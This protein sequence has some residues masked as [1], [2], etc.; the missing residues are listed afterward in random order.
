MRRLLTRIGK[1]P[2]KAVPWIIMTFG[3]CASLWLAWDDKSKLFTI[4]LGLT[5]A[6][7]AYQ[8]ARAPLDAVRAR[9]EM[10]ATN[11][12]AEMCEEPVKSVFDLFDKMFVSKAK[13]PQAEV[14]KRM[15]DIRKQMIVRG[16]ADL[17]LEWERFVEAVQRNSELEEKIAASER[18]FRALR[19]SIGHDDTDVPFGTF[20]ATY[21]TSE[22]RRKIS[23]LQ[24]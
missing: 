12:R 11:K 20:M 21:L 9:N 10:E 3:A 2:S 5:T 23:K 15:M 1:A 16:E 6:A 22:D 8:A 14:L 19:K 18:L 7:I 13:V 17:V 24:S 4:A